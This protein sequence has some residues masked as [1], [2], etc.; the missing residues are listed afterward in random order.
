M[1]QM[2]SVEKQY[3]SM[4][5]DRFLK[6]APTVARSNDVARPSVGALENLKAMPALHLALKVGVS[7]GASTAK[8]E[9]SFS[10]LKSIIRDRSQ[11]MHSRKAYRVQLAFESDLTKNRLE[12]NISQQ[13]STSNRRPQLF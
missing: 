11:S 2:L 8:C 3:L 12:K 13:L 6:K 1:L 5:A 10:L 7:H 9:N 4:T